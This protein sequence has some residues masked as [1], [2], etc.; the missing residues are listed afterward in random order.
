M[1]GQ[2]LGLRAPSLVGKKFGRLLAMEMIHRP[3]QRTWCRVICDCGKEKTVDAASLRYGAVRSCGCLR[4]EM[5][6]INGKKRKTHGVSAMNAL[7]YHVWRQMLQRCENPKHKDYPGWGGRGIT[8]CDDW[9][10]VLKFEAWAM[11]SGYKRKVTIERVDNM[12]NYCP[13]NCTWIPNEMQGKNTRRI[14]WI[15]Y[16]ERD[17][18][19]TEFCEEI[20]VKYRTVLGRLCRGMSPEEIAQT[21]LQFHTRFQK[22]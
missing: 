22:K 16:Q 11:S 17:I 20:G 13:E 5:S 3:Y 19:L 10:D 6:S 7:L 9:H 12:G 21:P 8:V 2:G 15:K 18:P 1:K 14:R 4:D